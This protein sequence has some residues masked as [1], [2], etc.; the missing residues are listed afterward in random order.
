MPP[1]CS[2]YGSRLQTGLYL[3]NTKSRSRLSNLKSVYTWHNSAK[4][5][6]IYDE[7]QAVA[8][9]EDADYDN[10]DGADN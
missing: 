6:H 3:Q 2:S 7:F 5:N 9:H 1:L 10:Q 8:D 4:L